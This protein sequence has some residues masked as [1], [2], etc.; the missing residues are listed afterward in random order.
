MR[1]SGSSKTAE[2]AAMTRTLA[3][4]SG[5]ASTVMF[6]PYAR[7][8]LGPSTLIPYLFNRFFMLVNPVFWRVGINSVGFLIALCR[9]RFMSDLIIKSMDENIKQIVLIGAGYDT[10]FLKIPEQ[11]KAANLFEIDHPNTQSRKIR[12]IRKHSLES[13]INLNYIGLDLEYDSITGQLHDKGLDRREAVLV[14]A[15]G[16]LSYLSAHSIDRL[17]HSLSNLSGKVRFAADYRLPQM[18]EK[19][20]NLAIKRWRM[21]FKMMHE[22][23]RSFFDEQDMEQ[24]LTEHGFQVIRHHNLAQLWNEYS[25]DKAPKQVQAV[26]GLFVSE[27]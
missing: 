15:E 27:N 1:K 17:F 18:K 26:A 8:F 5:Y 10:N 21:E 2:L 4:R 20:V 13:R 3:T 24:K 12:I 19:N 14:I 25:E 22:Q 7:Y 9:H 6:D 16:V 11:Y 23:Y